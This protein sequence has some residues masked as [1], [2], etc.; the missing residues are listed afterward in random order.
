MKRHLSIFVLALVVLGIL[1][2]E[3]V[4]L[5]E[6]AEAHYV[7]TARRT[8]DTEAVCVEGISETSHGNY[9][10]GYVKSHVRSMTWLP[11][12]WGAQHCGDAKP[13]GPGNLA[14]ALD[15]YHWRTV[16]GKAQWV[17]CRTLTYSYN[18]AR[19][20]RHT[21][22]A[23]WTYNCDHSKGAWFGTQGVGYVYDG[24]A[25]RGGWTWS[26]AHWLPA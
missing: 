19:T 6:P 18:T 23:H 1:S 5:A 17:R 8:Y 4:L 14:A 7:N 26:G 20:W 10:F 22:D 2:S 15:Y 16:D 24:A 11:T 3:V 9:G 13:R 21:L 25:W 12:P